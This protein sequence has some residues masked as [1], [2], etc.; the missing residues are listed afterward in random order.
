M[1]VASRA[2]RARA[3]DGRRLAE[4]RE[5]VVVR[6]RGRQ[7]AR[8]DVHG[9]VRLGVGRDGPRRNDVAQCRVSRDRPVDVHGTG[10]CRDARPED[11]P[12]AEGITARDA[13]LERQ[14]C[15][16]SNLSSLRPDG[17]TT[18]A[19]VP[20]MSERLSKR[21]PDCTVHTWPGAGHYGVYG[22]WEEL[23]GALV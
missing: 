18:W 23:L 5:A 22:R 7:A 2:E 6:S 11:H 1:W 8:V 19:N 14:P 9:V 20:E 16:G 12:V 3:P 21:L 10:V 13:V 15:D 17:T 4:R